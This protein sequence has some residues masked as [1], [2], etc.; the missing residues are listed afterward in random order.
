MKTKFIISGIVLLEIIFLSA[1]RVFEIKTLENRYNGWDYNASL[2]EIEPS[3]WDEAV[4]SPP[5]EVAEFEIEE[6]LEVEFNGSNVSNCPSEFIVRLNGLE[7]NGKEEQFHDQKKYV[8]KNGHLNL[9]SHRLEKVPNSIS[10]E[11][12][13]TSIDLDNN[14]LKEFPLELFFLKNLS[15]LSLSNNY[16]STIEGGIVFSELKHLDLSF[17]QITTLSHS[18][19]YMT[20][21]ENLNLSGN[22]SLNDLPVEKLKQLP[23]LKVIDIKHTALAKD[24]KYLRMIK[25]ELTITN[26]VLIN[27]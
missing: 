5:E 25:N 2:I 17:N 14:R 6:E 15:Y 19:G 7:L 23:N 26:G 1:T 12:C 20:K 16:I 10:D 22:Y 24:V 27:H 21:L 9:S 8:I 13:I 4:E 18:I 11:Q 3:E